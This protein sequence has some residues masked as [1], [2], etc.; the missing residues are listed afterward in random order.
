MSAFD[1]K[2]GDLSANVSNTS[3]II[4]KDI[5][6]TIIFS[7]EYNI[8]LPI[9]AQKI[10]ENMDN[11]RLFTFVENDEEITSITYDSENKSAKCILCLQSSY[12]PRREPKE[13][14]F[15][16]DETCKTPEDRANFIRTSSYD[17]N[18]YDIIINSNEAGYRNSGVYIYYHDKVYELDYISYN[19]YG[20]L[21]AWIELRK[22]DCGYSYFEDRLVDSY[23]TPLNLK[24][25]YIME[26]NV[27]NSPPTF[28]FYYEEIYVEFKL[29]RIKDGAECTLVLP[30]LLSSKELGGP[31]ESFTEGVYKSVGLYNKSITIKYISSGRKL[32]LKY[33]KLRCGKKVKPDDSEFNKEI[34]TQIIQQVVKEGE[35]YLETL[36]KNGKV[37][38]GEQSSKCYIEYEMPE[39]EKPLCVID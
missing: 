4:V 12:I 29:Y 39:K 16:W 34:T 14:S 35:T 27:V 15:A 31:T 17:I 21:P 13:F 3:G 2:T 11:C 18:D 20:T 25:W 32:K 22:E 36:K 5:S 28:S 33:K 9:I 37:I 24:E 7:S 30:V 10:R 8:S 23:A 38:Y 6:G 1:D 26:G 19:D